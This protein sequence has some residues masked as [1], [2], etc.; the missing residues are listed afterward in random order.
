M[1]I[2]ESNFYGKSVFQATVGLPTHVH[3]ELAFAYNSSQSLGFLESWMLPPVANNPTYWNTFR[4]RPM[5]MFIKSFGAY[6]VPVVKY[7]GA[8]VGTVANGKVAFVSLIDAET[9]EW[10]YEERD[11]DTAR[12][13][14]FAGGHPAIEDED[15][16]DVFDPFCFDG[17]LCEVLQ[18]EGNTPLDGTSG[19]DEVVA[20]LYEDPVYMSNFDREAVRAADVVMPSKI[21]IQLEEGCFV[22]DTN[23]PWSGTYDI[24]EEFFD[25]LY[26]KGAS[27]SGTNSGQGKLQPHILEYDSDLSFPTLGLTVSEMPYHLHREG[28]T[29]GAK[30]W[31]YGPTA[32]DMD[33]HRYVWK[34]VVPYGPEDDP[35][36][37]NLEIRVVMEH[38]L[39][40]PA[41]ADSQ[42]GG[43]GTTNEYG[44]WGATFNIYIFTDELNEEW[45]EGVTSFSPVDFS[46]SY[47]WSR[48]NPFS[49]GLSNA[50]TGT[51]TGTTDQKA[52]KK[53]IHPQCV[54]CATMAMSWHSPIGKN[55][56]PLEDQTYW[57]P[58][59]QSFWDG[60]AQNL[61]ESYVVANGSPW[62][63]LSSCPSDLPIRYSV[64]DDTHGILYNIIFGWPSPG[65]YLGRA[66]TLGGALPSSEISEWTCWENGNTEG[67]TFLAPIKPGWIED[68]G[69]LDVA[70]GN[71][72][73]VKICSSD[74]DNGSETAD[75]DRTWTKYELS[76]CEGHPDEDFESIGG[77]HSCFKTS[78]GV[79]AP[80]MA[81]PDGGADPAIF[82][83]VPTDEISIVT[84]YEYCTTHSAR[85]GDRSGSTCDIE[86]LTCTEFTAFT[87]FLVFPDDY[88]MSPHAAQTGRQMNWRRIQGI[89]GHNFRNMTDFS[90]SGIV[91]IGSW[92]FATDSAFMIS[93]GGTDTIKGMAHHNITDD[94]SWPWYGISIVTTFGDTLSKAHGIGFFYEELL[95]RAT[96]WGILVEPFDPDSVTVKL[97]FYSLGN[98]SVVID[99]VQLDG[100]STDG[101][102]RF[103]QIG[104]EIINASYVPTTGPSV[105]FILRNEWA[106]IH[107]WDPDLEVSAFF[108]ALFSTSS[109]FGASFSD[110]VI[111]DL[112]PDFEDCAE[113][114]IH[115]DRVIATLNPDHWY[116]AIR[117]ACEAESG[118]CCGSGDPPCCHCKSWAETLL[119]PSS[120]FSHNFDTSGDID[121]E[122]QITNCSIGPDNA[123]PDSDPWVADDPTFF[124]GP[125]PHRCDCDKKVC[126]NP[127]VRRCPKCQGVSISGS[128]PLPISQP[129]WAVPEDTSRVPK[130]SCFAG[131]PLVCRG[132]T[133]Y[134]ATKVVCD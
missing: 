25:T 85:Y 109:S 11:L 106:P 101:E 31:T 117:G 5:F 62:T 75:D 88:T 17:D 63:D 58:F 102:A 59:Q 66:M 112:V 30:D 127:D 79:I 48:A 21:L 133:V 14:S 7:T 110:L 115:D 132:L 6:P 126:G 39:T 111:L 123:C 29:A 86:E 93:A 8:T 13:A 18:L 52:A 44:A 80:E 71:C 4:G 51:E 56:V 118:G 77:S 107:V 22:R 96:G 38:T 57:K 32:A 76:P 122:A 81:Q 74:G 61:D 41:Q 20:P 16:P 49:S 23:H 113:G 87:T 54:A 15:I 1:P 84:G 2:S 55:F 105:D 50:K 120:S 43:I 94:G 27:V 37:F 95:N 82:C 24:I 114:A 67:Q 53:G 104:T 10:Q 47:T 28:P 98:E 125:S 69:E 89:P 99:S 97:V 83:C 42:G 72:S 90:A 33:V 92:F 128:F 116:L 9:E 124:G 91:D 60:R 34:I 19:L 40:A 45:K 131:I 70:G 3:P 121:I 100:V 65:D 119:A 73:T 36:A 78:A 26:G 12:T 130:I 108:P 103:L 129:S 134:N 68:C 46:G 35:E 64:P